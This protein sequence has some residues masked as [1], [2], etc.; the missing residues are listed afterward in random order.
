M[1]LCFND[2]VDMQTVQGYC[3]S[4]DLQNQVKRQYVQISIIIDTA[5]KN[6]ISGQST[7]MAKSWMDIMFYVVDTAFITLNSIGRLVIW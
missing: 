3:N 4:Q 1:H 5:I 2:S 7:P 6:P